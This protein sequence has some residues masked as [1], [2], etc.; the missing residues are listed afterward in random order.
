V[1]ERF[2][3]TNHSTAIRRII[4][5]MMPPAIGPALDR[6]DEGVAGIDDVVGEGDEVRTEVDEVLRK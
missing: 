4:P 2:F 5:P 6:D 1:S 3:L